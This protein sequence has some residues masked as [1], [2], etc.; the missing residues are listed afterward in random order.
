MTNPFKEKW[1]DMH[2]THDVKVQEKL[3]E[4][5]EDVHEMDEQLDNIEEESKPGAEAK[6]LGIPTNEVASVMDSLNF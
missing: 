2:K 1:A 4:A 6:K 3:D 5:K